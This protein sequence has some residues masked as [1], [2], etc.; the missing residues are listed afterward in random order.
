MRNFRNFLK[1]LEEATTD[2]KAPTAAIASGIPPGF[3]LPDLT[4]QDYGQA[5]S[6]FS[7]L[8][9]QSSSQFNP[10][11]KLLDKISKLVWNIVNDKESY[12]DQRKGAPKIQIKGTPQSGEG[13]IKNINLNSIKTRG[14]SKGHLFNPSELYQL[15]ID[16]PYGSSKSNIIKKSS[17]YPGYINIDMQ[18]LA[19]QMQQIQNKLT[20]KTQIARAGDTITGLMNQQSSIGSKPNTSTH[21]A[22]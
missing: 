9:T 21:G 4:G 16:N 11:V 6:S 5:A 10:D 14:Q 18:E 17:E 22:I 7:D 20:Y 2:P 3:E 15:G 8:A 19:Q 12:E 1:R 13:L